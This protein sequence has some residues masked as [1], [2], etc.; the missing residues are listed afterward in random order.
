[1][2][3]WEP[4]SV[5]GIAPLTQRCDSGRPWLRWATCQHAKVADC[6]LQQRHGAWKLPARIIC[7][8]ER[9]HPLR[10]PPALL[11]ELMHSASQRVLKSSKYGPRS[12]QRLLGEAAKVSRMLHY[13]SGGLRKR[14]EDGLRHASAQRTAQRIYFPYSS[15]RRVCQATCAIHMRW[16]CARVCPKRRTQN[17]TELAWPYASAISSNSACFAR[18]SPHGSWWSSFAATAQCLQSF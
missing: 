8:L 10:R 18:S 14:R 9:R 7:V 4:R 11:S 3:R 16:T 1:M 5:S 13:P 12:Q 2:W 15:A 6:Q 17:R